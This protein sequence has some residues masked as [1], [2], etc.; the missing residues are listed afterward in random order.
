MVGK[1][2]RETSSLDV[3]GTVT[4]VQSAKFL[5]GTQLEYIDK[6]LEIEANEREARE[7]LHAVRK[8]VGDCHF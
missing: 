1:V 7:K 4:S 3:V 8:Q 2:N 5:L 6:Q